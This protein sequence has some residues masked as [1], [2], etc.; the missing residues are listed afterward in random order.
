MNN[1][2]ATIGPTSL[3][4]SNFNKDEKD[5]IQILVK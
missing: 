1:K 2:T 3:A 4:G 5:K